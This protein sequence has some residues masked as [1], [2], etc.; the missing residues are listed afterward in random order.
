VTT[1]YLYWLEG[2]QDK[3]CAKMVEAIEGTVL[4]RTGVKEKKK[5]IVLIIFIRV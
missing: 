3:S 1:I 4:V 5:P 2:E